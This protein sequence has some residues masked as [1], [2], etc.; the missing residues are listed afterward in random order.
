MKRPSIAPPHIFAW[1]AVAFTWIVV[2]CS[3]AA[4][5][6]EQRVLNVADIVCAIDAFDPGLAPADVQAALESACGKVPDIHK[7]VDAQTRALS[8]ASARAAMRATPA[9]S[10]STAPASSR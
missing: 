6:A 4:K 5:Q 9:A 2:A 8:R 1:P 7:I 10:A 3:P